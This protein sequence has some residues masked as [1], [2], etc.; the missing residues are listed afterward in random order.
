MSLEQQKNRESAFLPNES[1]FL[2]SA[3]RGSVS[4]ILTGCQPESFLWPKRH[5]H[6]LQLAYWMGFSKVLLVGMDFSYQIPADAKVDGN[7]I[8]S[9]SDDPNHFD[10]RYFGAGKTWKENAGAS[11]L[12]TRKRSF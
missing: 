11:E 10:P 3:D 8:V 7:I 5:D 1:R 6:N 12:Q 4:T 2:R 9:Q